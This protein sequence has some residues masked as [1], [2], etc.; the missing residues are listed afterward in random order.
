M[1]KN[2]F[3]NIG[4]AKISNKRKQVR[5]FLNT[6][7]KKKI[8]QVGYY[9]PTIYRTYTPWRSSELQKLTFTPKA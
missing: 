5:K 7:F 2:T 3:Y 8:K 4:K 1:Q 9:I 6:A